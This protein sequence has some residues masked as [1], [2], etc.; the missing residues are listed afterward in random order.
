MKNL[1]ITLL[2]L[3]LHSFA[4]AQP[5]AD[6]LLDFILKNKSRSALYVVK[7]D[8]VLAKQNENKMMPLASTVKI[9]VAVEFAKQAGNGVVDADSYIPLSELDKYYIP[10]TDGNAHRNWLSYEKEKNHI[11]NDSVQLI[12]VARGMTIFSSNANT[13]YLMDLLGLE[14]IKSNIKLF[15]LTNHGT[16]YPIVSSL[17]LYQNQ[18]NADEKKI[19]KA[20]GKLTEEQYCQTILQIHNALKN[21]APL[22]AKFRPQDL[23]MAMQKMWSD[24]LTASTVKTYVQ[25]CSILNNR[26]FLDE[27]S[28]AVLSKLLEYFMESTGNQKIYKHFGIKGGSTAFVL[29]EAFY[30]TTQ[31]G[32]RMEAAYF[33]ND[34]TENEFGKLESWIND[35]RIGVTQNEKFAAK[36]KGIAW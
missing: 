4:G 20:I 29:T 30:A 21:N 22:K 11:K 28:Y 5:G 33:F 36:L 27:K 12:N 35:M 31:K 1:K 17:F 9:L 23:T 16:V 26:K 24:R 19:L 32:D 2:L 15:G 13:E 8:T 25:L 6:S 10:N 7:N 18:K 3:L 34:L 14:N